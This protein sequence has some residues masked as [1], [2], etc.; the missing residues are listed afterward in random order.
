[1]KGKPYSQVTDF[2]A[3]PDNVLKAQEQKTAQIA[4]L[5]SSKVIVKQVN[6]SLGQA[7]PHFMRW[8]RSERRLSKP[9]RWVFP[10]PKNDGPRTT[11]QKSHTRAVRGVQKKDGNYEG[12]CGIQCRLYDMRHTF[13]TRFAPASCVAARPLRSR[14]CGDAQQVRTSVAA[15]YGP[16]DGVVRGSSINCAP[17]FSRDAG[18]ISGSQR[19]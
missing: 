10:S 15:R 9:G 6:M 16:R 4:Q 14:R 12:G 18:G 8:Y 3:V 1:L 2:T 13:A 11:V 5:K 19:H 17:S 7:I